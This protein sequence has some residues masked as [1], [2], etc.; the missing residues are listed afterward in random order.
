LK[1]IHDNGVSAA[2]ARS[3]G[4][5][6]QSQQLADV[7][8]PLQIFSVSPD[9]RWIASTIDYRT[10]RI[11]D[12][13]T[14]KSLASF[15]NDRALRFGLGGA[16]LAWCLIWVASGVRIA[17][18]RPW[19]DGILILG[20]PLAVLTAYAAARPIWAVDRAAV[21]VSLALLTSFLGLLILWW[22]HGRLR[23]SLRLACLVA[24]SAA[25]TAGLLASGHRDDPGVWN[26]ILGAVS[27]IAGLAMLLTSWRWRRLT[28]AQASEAVDAAARWQAP[29]KD[30]LLV[31]A[32]VS[33]L[34]AV[35]RFAEPGVRDRFT[36]AYVTVIGSGLAATVFASAWAALS[37]RRIWPIFAAGA[38]AA[39]G[40]ALPHLLF[41]ARSTD[42][43]WWCE[44]L[45][46]ATATAIYISLSIFRLHGYRLLGG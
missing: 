7:A 46:A 30:L 2:I 12:L 23:W 1:S 42:P 4:T 9:E 19:L 18:P 35:M 6:I 43:L 20:V 14:G 25:I 8:G 32:A 41:G 44:T 21:A 16:Y 29:L 3:T 5:I 34:L 22:I 38:V 17:H 26:V 27:F 11:W 28:I 13:A 31:I 36:L 40:G 45:H 15:S 24:G 33:L 10:V 39:I 37:P